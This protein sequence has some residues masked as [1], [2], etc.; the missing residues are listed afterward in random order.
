MKHSHIILTSLLVLLALNSSAQK[1]ANF[2]RDYEPIRNEL[3]SWDGVR[4]AWLADNLPAVVNQQPV[5][6]RNF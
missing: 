4:G 6:V 2:E 1:S 5:G 3:K